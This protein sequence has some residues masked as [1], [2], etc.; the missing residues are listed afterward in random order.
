MATGWASGW[1][2]L[3]ADRRRSCSRMSLVDVAG[4][5]VVDLVDPREIAHRL[6]GQVDVGMY[7]ELLRELDDRAVG[8][9]DMP[10]GAAL[11]PQAGHHVDDQVDLVRQQGVQVDEASAGQLGE[12]MSAVSFVCSVRRPRCCSNSSRSAF[13]ACAFLASTRLLVTSAMSQG[14]RWTCRAGSDP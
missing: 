7:Q 6:I 4:D 13:W 12:R 1:F 3:V 5:Q 14:S 9:A 11:G 10:A 2:D 8:P